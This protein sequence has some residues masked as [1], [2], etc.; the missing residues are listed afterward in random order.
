MGTKRIG[1]ELQNDNFM[2]SIDESIMRDIHVAI[3]SFIFG[4]WKIFS[5]IERATLQ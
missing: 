2:D 1:V 4:T 3:D 5:E